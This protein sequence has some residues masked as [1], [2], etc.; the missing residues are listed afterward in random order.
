MNWR[1]NI[2]NSVSCFIGDPLVLT[3]PSL[4]TIGMLRLNAFPFH[5]CSGID[6]IVWRGHFYLVGRLYENGARW[7]LLLFR[8]AFLGTYFSFLYKGERCTDSYSNALA[9]RL[10]PV[11]SNHRNL[12]NLSYFWNW[13]LRHVSSPQCLIFFVKLQ[14]SIY[15]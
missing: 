10:S 12:Q 5:F 4:G 9:S 13:A 15:V 6:W 8:N 2:D 7:L 1:W 3:Y 14:R 11:Y